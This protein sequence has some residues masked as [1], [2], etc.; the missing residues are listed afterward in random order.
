MD[1]KGQIYSF[2]SNRFDKLGFYQNSIDNL[3]VPTIIP[4]INVF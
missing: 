4:N 3:S 2:G 1:D